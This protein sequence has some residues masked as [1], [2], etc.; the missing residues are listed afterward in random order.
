MISD[1]WAD[2]PQSF[3]D[4]WHPDD[5][6]ATWRSSGLAAV[7]LLPSWLA[8]QLADRYEEASVDWPRVEKMATGT[9]ASGRRASSLVSGKAAQDWCPEVDALIEPIRLIAES[10]V[11]RPVC[12][13]HL[14]SEMTVKVYGEGDEQGPHL[15]SN[16]LTA[17]LIL[18]GG[19]PEFIDMPTL[20]SLD[21][22]AMLLFQ[23]RRLWHRVPPVADRKVSVVINLY[24]PEDQWRPAVQDALI[25]GGQ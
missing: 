5:A 4:Y 3:S 7:Q 16:P 6:H 15:D 23:G 9:R 2:A 11:R 14:G 10:V 12:R 17:L 21:P 22:G 13:A 8:L 25:Y 19:P 20:P 24:H 18:D 1:P